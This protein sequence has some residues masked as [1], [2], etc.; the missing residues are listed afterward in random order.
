MSNFDDSCNELMTL[1]L[2]RDNYVSEDDIKHYYNVAP[3]IVDEINL[4]S[5]N[6]EIYTIIYKKVM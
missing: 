3:I 5:N 2:F 1:R 4:L 6:R